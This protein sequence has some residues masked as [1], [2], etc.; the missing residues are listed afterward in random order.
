MVPIYGKVDVLGGHEKF[1]SARMVG[2]EI[3]KLPVVLKKGAD[4][5]G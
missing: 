4:T 5:A 1:R 2:A 3:P